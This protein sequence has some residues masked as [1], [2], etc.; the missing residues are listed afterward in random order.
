MTSTADGTSSQPRTGRRSGRP[1]RG[2]RPR[3]SGD[4]PRMQS[5]Q[6][7]DERELGENG[8][9][10]GKEDPSARNGHVSILDQGRRA[11]ASKREVVSIGATTYRQ[12]LEDSGSSVAGKT[13]WCAEGRLRP[14]C[15]QPSTGS[16]AATGAEGYLLHD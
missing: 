13:G 3:L 7:N 5:V 1:Y 12:L 9:R 6:P 14:M 8:S 4:E 16:L 15:L 10:G 2:G 11:P